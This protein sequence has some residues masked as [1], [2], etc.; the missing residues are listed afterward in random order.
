MSPGAPSRGFDLGLR[1]HLLQ[2]NLAGA[3]EEAPRGRIGP[4]QVLAGREGSGL[5]LEQ[6]HHRQN[7]WDQQPL[8][9]HPPSTIW[10]PC[11]IKSNHSNKKSQTQLSSSLK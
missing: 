5:R 7:P 6:D 11:C 1:Q 2:A 4:A 3:Q 10:G 8:L 9:P